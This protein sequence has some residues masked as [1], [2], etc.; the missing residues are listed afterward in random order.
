M[1]GVVLETQFFEHR[2]QDNFYL[3]ISYRIKY[4]MYKKNN[5]NLTKL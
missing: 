1:V 3:G 5:N 4:V 2:N